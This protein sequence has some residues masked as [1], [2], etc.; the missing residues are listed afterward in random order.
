MSQIPAVCPRCGA[1]HQLT[2]DALPNALTCACGAQLTLERHGAAVLLNERTAEQI[3]SEKPD[4]QAL[5]TR[6]EAEKLPVERYALYQQALALDPN[7]FAVRWALLL[8]GRLHECVKRPGDF[9]VIKCYLLHPF[10]EPEAYKEPKRQE[11]MRELFSSPDLSSLLASSGDAQRTMLAYL[12]HLSR[13]YIALF[14]RGRTAISHRMFGFA[15]PEEEIAKLCAAIV[16]GMRAR[17]L[18]DQD[19]TEEQRDL[20]YRA[21]GAAFA[22]EFP[23]KEELLLTALDELEQPRKGWRLFG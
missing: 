23:N 2:P 18:R 15:R 14:L 4:V 1:V 19:L 9:T 8:H 16:A 12:Q 20:L 11:V 6:A 7:S 22:Q 5:L 3:R 13:E 21:L 17:V 10:E